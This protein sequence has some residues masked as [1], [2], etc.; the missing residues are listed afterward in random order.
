M[1]YRNIPC[2]PLFVPVGGSFGLCNADNANL[3]SYKE[4]GNSIYKHLRIDPSSFD[5]LHL[6]GND[7]FEIC[8]Y[9]FTCG[10]HSSTCTEQHDTILYKCHLHFNSNYRRICLRI[11]TM[12]E[13]ENRQL[14]KNSILLKAD[15]KLKVLCYSKK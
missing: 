12:Y 8:I 1:Q 5:T 6:L 3:R 7:A 10:R 11:G 2:L 9:Y 13:G 14:D 4:N 15:E